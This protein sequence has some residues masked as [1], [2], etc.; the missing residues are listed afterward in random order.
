[1]DLFNELI[2]HNKNMAI[3]VEKQLEKGYEMYKV[4]MKANQYYTYNSSSI[5]GYE[6]KKRNKWIVCS[7]QYLKEIERKKHVQLWYS[8][9]ENGLHIENDFIEYVVQIINNLYAF[10]EGCIGP[11]NKKYS[12]KDQ[13][14]IKD[15][16]NYTN[17]KKDKHTV[18]ELVNII[19]TK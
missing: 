13:W 19:I 18:L 4:N 3:D 1:V 14:K 2:Y 17:I 15:N 9:F 6:N 7:A 8:A 11:N 16:T 10:D 5:D 12:K